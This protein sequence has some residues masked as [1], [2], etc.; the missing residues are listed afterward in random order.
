MAKY[1]IYLT[2]Y[3]ARALRELYEDSIITKMLKPR[4][5]K[6]LIRIGDKIER[7]AD[8]NTW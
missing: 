2:E 1:K 3:E 6:V 5:L 7:Q 8:Y 4:V